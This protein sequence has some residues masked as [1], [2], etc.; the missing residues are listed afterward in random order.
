MP[1]KKVII[2]ALKNLQNKI[3]NLESNANKTSTNILES[4][5]YTAYPVSTDNEDTLIDEFNLN[6]ED[7]KTSITE[8]RISELEKQLAKMQSLLIH[9]DI[10]SDSNNNFDYDYEK[11]GDMNFGSKNFNKQKVVFKFIRIY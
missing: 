11:N 2:N 6:K 3:K 1:N 9:D 10:E 5:I 8:K 4:N 7:D